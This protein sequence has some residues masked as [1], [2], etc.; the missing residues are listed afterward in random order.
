MRNTPRKKARF[1]SKNWF[2]ESNC[3]ALNADIG[4][5]FK[6]SSSSRFASGGLMKPMKRATALN[7]EVTQDI[8]KRVPSP[9]AIFAKAWILN[10]YSREQPI[11]CAE[12]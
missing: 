6:K 5:L 3:L 10:A 11:F 2:S 8:A 4:L 7:A 9:K 12:C 1:G